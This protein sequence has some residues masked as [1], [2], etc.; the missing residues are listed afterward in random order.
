MKKEKRNEELIEEVKAIRSDREAWKVITSNKYRKKRI[1]ICNDIPKKKWKEN[2]MNLLGRKEQREVAK[3]GRWKE[4]DGEPDLTEEEIEEQIRKLKVKMATGEDQ[5]PSE[6]WKYCTVQ[7]K[8]KIIEV[9]QKV[10]TEEG[11]PSDWNK[12]II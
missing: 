1:K 12:G 2:F 6:A 8:E 10:W 7:V 3:E 9:M 5:I 11:M 4:E